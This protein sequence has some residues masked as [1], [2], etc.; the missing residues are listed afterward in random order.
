MTLKDRLSYKTTP[1]TF[2]Q[3][4][5]W[6]LLAALSAIA[7]LMIIDP[8]ESTTSAVKHFVSLCMGVIGTSHLTVDE[9]ATKIR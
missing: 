1:K 7:G 2:K 9:N 6:A 3:I 8:T 4:Q 5:F